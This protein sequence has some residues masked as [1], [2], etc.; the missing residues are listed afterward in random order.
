[1][2][3]GDEGVSSIRCHLDDLG[4]L[5]CFNLYDPR[6]IGSLINTIGDAQPL[7]R[8]PLWGDKGLRGIIDCYGL[9]IMQGDPQQPAVFREGALNGLLGIGVDR[10]TVFVIPPLGRGFKKSGL[11]GDLQGGGGNEPEIHSLE[12]HDRRITPV[13]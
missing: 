11:L 9:G 7:I 10:L 3:V 13:G 4:G 6:L 12:V 8:C 1:M 5:S 2:P